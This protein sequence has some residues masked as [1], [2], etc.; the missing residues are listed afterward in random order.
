MGLGISAR[1]GRPNRCL[2][3]LGHVSGYRKA[4]RPHQIAS[5]REAKVGQNEQRTSRSKWHKRWHSRIQNGALGQA[6]DITIMVGDR[7]LDDWIAWA[8][9][10]LAAHD[11]LQ[12]GAAAVFEAV[13]VID[14]W[15]YREDRRAD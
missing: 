12:A 6:G 14:Q 10:R 3:S 2:Q 5:T 13:A 8:R 9:D 7:T 4:Y 1:E 11:P 15:T